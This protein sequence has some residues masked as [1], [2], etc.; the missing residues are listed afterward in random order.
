MLRWP[1]LYMRMCNLA[2]DPEELVTLGDVSQ[3]QK[4]IPQD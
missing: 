4:E 3:D 1:G 2:A